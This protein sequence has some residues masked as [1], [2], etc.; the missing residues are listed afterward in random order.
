M[1][2]KNPKDV[3]RRIKKK[4]SCVRATL[5]I[6]FPPLKI[7]KKKLEQDQIGLSGRVGKNNFGPEC[8]KDG[9]KKKR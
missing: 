1:I 3:S 8:D 5:E 7:A 9:R 2:K 4:T 6:K